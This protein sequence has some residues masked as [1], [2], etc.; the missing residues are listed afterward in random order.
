RTFVHKFDRPASDPVELLDDIERTL[1]ISAAPVNWPVGNAEHFRGVY[2][3]QRQHLLL[4]ERE[5]QGQYRAPVDVADLDDP[6][7]R[8]LIGENTYAHFREPFDVIRA[9]G[10]QS[11]L[12]AY[13]TARPHRGLLG[14]SMPTFAS[15]R[16]LR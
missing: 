7:A 11:A 1:G 16:F 6:Q 2:D 10:T 13:T 12:D 9:A 5:M 8:E 4:Y 3:L 15:R 14:R